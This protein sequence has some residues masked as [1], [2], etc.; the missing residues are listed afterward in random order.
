[1]FWTVISVILL[2]V[3]LIAVI[4][5]VFSKSADAK[6]GALLVAV[7]VAVIGAVVFV[8]PSLRSVSATEVGV[9]V[10]FGQV[11]EPVGPGW[12]FIPAWTELDTYPTRPVT[13]ELA[14][15][16]K[17]LARTADA[18]QMTVEVAA[19]WQV[20][21]HEAKNLYLQVRTGDDD[22]ISQDVVVKNLRQAVGV[23]YSGIGNLD[24]INDRAKVSQL[25]KVQLQKQLDAYG[26]SVVDI[27]MRSVEPDER[28]AATLAAFASQQQATRIATEAKQTA[29]QEA[30]R[31]LTE[32]NGIKAAADAVKGITSG[33]AALVCMQIWQQSAAAATAAGVPLYTTP[34][35]GSNTAVVAPAKAG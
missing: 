18:G 7:I 31:R 30:A 8:L 34:C 32:A 19:R 17:I 11:Q 23:V 27:N 16:D 35:G 12:H 6:G 9:P 15:G 21:S 33:E 14:G 1:M 26:I 20:E 2:V 5:A 13:V 24:A 29:V 28:T 4:V 22:K 25:I 10:S 3:A